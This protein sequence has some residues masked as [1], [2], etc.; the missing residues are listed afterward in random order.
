MCMKYESRYHR[1][2]PTRSRLQRL[3][4]SQGCKLFQISAKKLRIVETLFQCFT[5]ISLCLEKYD[6]LFSLYLPNIIA[7]F[8]PRKYVGSVRYARN[9]FYDFV[10]RVWT[11]NCARSHH[12]AQN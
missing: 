4:I 11:L 12:G 3:Q 7:I 8:R 1:I 5:D 9:R 6:L 10:G 2:S